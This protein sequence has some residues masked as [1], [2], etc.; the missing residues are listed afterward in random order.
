MRAAWERPQG[1]RLLASG[2]VAT[3]AAGVATEASMLSKALSSARRSRKS[4]EAETSRAELLRTLVQQAEQGQAYALRATLQSI[5][6]DTHPDAVDWADAHGFTPLMHA[7]TE[8][9]A[10]V[11]TLLLAAGAAPD[12]C[13]P[14]RETALHLAASIGYGEVVRVLIDHGADPSLR[15]C[16][17][18]TASDLAAALGH[19]SLVGYL[20]SDL[21]SASSEIGHSPHSPHSRPVASA[22]A[23]EVELVELGGAALVGSSAPPDARDT[24]RETAYTLLDAPLAQLSGE[25]LDEIESILQMTLEHIA[26]LRLAAA[27]A[28]LAAAAP[29]AAAPG[30]LAAPAAPTAAAAAAAAAAADVISSTKNAAALARAKAGGSRGPST[31]TSPLVGRRSELN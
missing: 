1:L 15:T 29:T 24:V 17:G 26:E 11:V 20:T 14:Q 23:A 4:Q 16:G 28:E 22:A 18:A 10:E 31:N 9:H 21:S 30:A 6:P 25:E 13:N 3:A 5:C 19:E 2:T 8:G 12:A 27:A 7:C